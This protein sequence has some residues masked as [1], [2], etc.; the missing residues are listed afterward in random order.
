MSATARAPQTPRTP[1]K[2]NAGAQDI[3]LITG[4]NA[5]L[6]HTTALTL[7]KKGVLVVLGCRNLEAAKE[8]KQDLL[9][10]TGCP[11]EQVIVLDVV[12]DLSDLSSVRGYAAALRVWLSG[13]KLTSL[14]NNAGVGASPWGTRHHEKSGT[15]L[16][17]GTN[18][19]GEK[20]HIQPHAVWAWSRLDSPDHTPSP[21]MSVSSLFWK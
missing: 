21:L 3:V 13:R 15:E 8:S 9:R 18:H 17:F 4:A 20:R 2:K 7:V 6:G 12:L 1:K 10:L 19:L 11:P 14:V 16:C 5:G